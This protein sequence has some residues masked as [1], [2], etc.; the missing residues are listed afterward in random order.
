[1][2]SMGGMV[3]VG[4]VEALEVASLRELVIVI[5]VVLL[6]LMLALSR[7]ELTNPD[8][9]FWDSAVVLFSADESCAVLMVRRRISQPARPEVE[10]GAV[11]LWGSE[12]PD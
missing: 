7:I 3:V 2:A 12:T 8:T 9:E 4:V 1:M 11:G 5:V 6:M 10:D